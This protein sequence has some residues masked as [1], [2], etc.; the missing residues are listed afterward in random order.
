MKMKEKQIGKITHYYDKIKVGVIKLTGSLK[1]GDKI[2]I[3]GAHDDFV[4]TISSMQ[5]DHK[6]IKMGKKGQEIAV[7]VDQV[8]HK[9]DNVIK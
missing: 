1:V 8:V 6:E 9:N 4:Q 3:K 5:F 7:G 2:H